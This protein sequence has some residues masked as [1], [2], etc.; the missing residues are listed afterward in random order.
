MCWGMLLDVHRSYL[1]SQHSRRMSNVQECIAYQDH[2][3]RT[4]PL[5]NDYF[6]LCKCWGMLLD[7]HQSYLDSQYSH[8]MSKVEKYIAYQD[9]HRRIGPLR[10]AA[11]SCKFGKFL[12]PHQNCLSSHSRKRESNMK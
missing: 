7:V 6:F 11:R 1:D 3:R 8:R 9:H 10:N 12:A 5:R 2:H 4:G